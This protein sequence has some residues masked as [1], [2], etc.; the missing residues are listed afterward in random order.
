M[1][2]CGL[3]VVSCVGHHSATQ[4]TSG[5][6]SLEGE[7]VQPTGLEVWVHALLG[8]L[9]LGSVIA[10][11]IVWGQWGGWI[12][13]PSFLPFPFPPSFFLTFHKTS[14]PSQLQTPYVTEDVFEPL[15]SPLPMSWNY[16]QVSSHS[17]FMDGWPLQH[18]YP[19]TLAI[20]FSRMSLV[21]SNLS[22]LPHFLVLLQPPV[23]PCWELSIRR[24]SRSKLQN[25]HGKNNHLEAGR[26]QPA[27]FN[28][29]VTREDK[30][31][32]SQPTLL[33]TRGWCP[34]PHCTNGSQS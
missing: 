17:L 32:P 3:A 33:P 8:P 26:T 5:T 4:H 18:L 29:G 20:T 21:S 6:V 28:T 2:G 11:S 30:T 24:H 27:H 15:A 34:S 13:S 22:S 7:V 25:L 16:R 9:L 31:A 14:S 1:L 19:Q 12:P 10:E 23:A